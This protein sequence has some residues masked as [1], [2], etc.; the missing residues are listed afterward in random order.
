ME[1]LQDK[2]P[3]KDAL[4]E[5]IPEGIKQFTF[6]IEKGILFAYK[7]ANNGNVSFVDL[8]GAIGI[9]A[10]H[11]LQCA[12]L[13]YGYLEDEK[14]KAILYDNIKKSFEYYKKHPKWPDFN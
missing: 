1:K 4:W 12:C 2:D 13:W 14:V 8:V 10:G 9:A 7:E 6:S 5:K 3:M 11:Y